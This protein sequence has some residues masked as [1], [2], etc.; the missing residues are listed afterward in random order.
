MDYLLLE[1]HVEAAQAHST[2]FPIILAYSL[3]VNTKEFGEILGA[4]RPP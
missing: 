2:Q 4:K 3:L 1:E